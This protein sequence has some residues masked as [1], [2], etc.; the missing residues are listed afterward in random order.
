[1]DNVVFPCS[2]YTALHDGGKLFSHVPDEPPIRH[3]HHAGQ[4][5]VSRDAHDA[6]LYLF[7]LAWEGRTCTIGHSN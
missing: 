3:G 2:L 4:R 7:I 1:M 5:V 6:L